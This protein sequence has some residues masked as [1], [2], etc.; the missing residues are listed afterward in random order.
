M[1]KK[2]T[3]DAGSRRDPDVSVS[4]KVE[5]ILSIIDEEGAPPLGKGDWVK[6]LEGIITDCE[7]RLEAAREELQ[8][9]IEP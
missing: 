1:V 7:C 4:T 3:R 8:R 9:Q 2:S 6:L 5:R